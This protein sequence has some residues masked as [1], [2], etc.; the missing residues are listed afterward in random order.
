MLCISL[1]AQCRF[2]HTRVLAPAHLCA[3]LLQVLPF[4]SDETVQALEHNIKTVPPVSDI[5]AKGMSLE[6]LLGVMLHGIGV[7]ADEVTDKIVYYG[8]CEKEALQVRAAQARCTHACSCA[9]MC[10]AHASV[11]PPRAGLAYALLCHM[12]V[13]ASGLCAPARTCTLRLAW[14]ATAQ[15]ARA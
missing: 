7:D 11:D 1:Q 2:L 14:R 3:P 9:R 8:P 10:G 4:A 15:R 13:L 6:E 5:L 12:G